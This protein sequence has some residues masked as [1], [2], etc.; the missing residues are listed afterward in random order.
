MNK[1]KKDK[2]QIP[3]EMLLELLEAIGDTFKYSTE[4][5]TVSHYKEPFA[6]MT[7]KA[8]TLAEELETQLLEKESD[9]L[10]LPKRKG[11]GMDEEQ[12][13]TGKVESSVLD[14]S[15]EHLRSQMNAIRIDRAMSWQQVAL[16][17]GISPHE[18]ERWGAGTQVSARTLIAAARWLRQQKKG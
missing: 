1:Q 5:G 15:P 11:H 6:R 17:A 2:V 14:D 7:A 3:T 8:H 9:N 18:F 13:E 16:E 10:G 4:H 12:A